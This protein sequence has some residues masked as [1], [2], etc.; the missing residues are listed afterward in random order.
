MIKTFIAEPNEEVGLDDPRCI[1][2][3]ASSQ[4][5][6]F[7]VVFL[8]VCVKIDTK[9]LASLQSFPDKSFFPFQ[10]SQ[11]SEPFRIF[12]EAN[13][14][15]GKPIIFQGSHSNFKE[16]NPMSVCSL[17]LRRVMRQGTCFDATGPTSC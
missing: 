4:K 15:S 17:L 14:I 6:A 2:H 7:N 9:M 10:E 16:A 8:R 12:K 11:Q 1:W 13:P 3:F 5:S